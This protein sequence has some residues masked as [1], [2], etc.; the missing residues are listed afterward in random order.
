[1]SFLEEAETLATLHL[2]INDK[3]VIDKSL[4]PYITMPIKDVVEDVVLTQKTPAG[5]LGDTVLYLGCSTDIVRCLLITGASTLIGIDLVDTLFY[6]GLEESVEVN[7]FTK[8]VTESV[9][10]IKSITHNIQIADDREGEKIIDYLNISGNKLVADFTLAGIKRHVVVYVGE[11]ANTFRPSEAQNV[12]VVFLSAM[13]PSANFFAH[14][15]PNYYVSNLI[16]EF[17][18]VP[19][20][21]VTSFVMYPFASGVMV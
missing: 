6:P 2:S 7:E 3:E 18:M 16:T 8:G 4:I 13:A 1:M 10:I 17:L 14:Y 9:H 11:D 15:K 19:I 20:W 12:D 5:R 21:A